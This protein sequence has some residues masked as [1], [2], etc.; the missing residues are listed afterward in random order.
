M[1]HKKL[2]KILKDIEI[3]DHLTCLLK[4]LY[5]EQKLTELDVEQWTGSKL[6]KEYI[7]INNSKPI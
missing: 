3:P 2:W 6:Q 7:I 1:D 4:N 5:A